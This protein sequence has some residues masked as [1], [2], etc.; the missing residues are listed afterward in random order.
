MPDTS[1]PIKLRAPS[2]IDESQ[3]SKPLQDLFA[4]WRDSLKEPFRGITASG[5]VELDLF[6]ERD[7]GSVEPLV[8]AATRFLASLNDAERKTVTSPLESEVWRHWSNIH[9]NLMRHGLCLVELSEEQRDLAYEFLK[10][11]LGPR[12]YDTARKAMKLN[13]T[14]AEM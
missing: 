7:G 2:R 11:G 8:K 3:V 13:Q 14:L 1:S 4:S 5:Q 12:A 10:T 6:K 9:R